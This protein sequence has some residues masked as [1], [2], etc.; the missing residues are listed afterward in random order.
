MFALNEKV[1]YPSHGVAKVNKL[2]KKV[3]N[4]NEKT[5]YELSFL[6][7][8]IT[9]L[10]PTDNIDN[11]GIR[12]L[13]SNEKIDQIIDILRKPAKKDNCSEF[14]SLTWNKRSK[15]YQSK[16]RSG[17]LK[18]ISEIYKDLIY[19]S[20][21]KELSFGEKNLLQKTEYL[22]VEEI[23]IVKKLEQKNAIEYLRSCM[24]I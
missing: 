21:K 17:D 1:V 9:I 22:L 6:N 10:V 14:I 12:P 7:K 3:I 11:V 18:Q 8:D 13:A 20:K 24:Q 2:V 4:G 19:I 23:S 5:F 16:L 15:D